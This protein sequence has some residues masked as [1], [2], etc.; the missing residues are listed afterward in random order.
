MHAIYGWRGTIGMMTP[1]LGPQIEFHKKVPDGVAVCSTL[2][3]LLES[4]PKGLLEMSAHIE[5]AAA[6]LALHRPDLILFACTTGS[7][8]NGMGYDREITNRI[9]RHTGIP[10][11]TTATAIVRA[12]ER[13][14]VKKVSITTP[15]IEELNRAEKSFFE[16]CGFE[17]TSIKGLGLPVDDIADVRPEQMYRFTKEN[18]T[19]DADAALISCT[20]LCV[21][22]IIE[23]LETDLGRPVVTSVQ[24]SLWEA[25]KRIGVLETI[26]GLGTLLRS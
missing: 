21:S 19:A 9:E 15:Y 13:L 10:A 8:L 12:F 5:T 23:P 6:L 24:A 18:V 14:Q 2:L 20:G 16:A 22:G 3:P 17:V 1:G 11:T 25:L 7:L 26:G 4:S